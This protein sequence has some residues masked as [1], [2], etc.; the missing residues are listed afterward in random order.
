M[1][2]NPIIN[3]DTLN[4]ELKSLPNRLDFGTIT[5]LASQVTSQFQAVKQSTLSTDVN[6]VVNGFQ[7]LTQEVDDGFSTTSEKG[8]AVLTENPPGLNIKKPT[9]GANADL[10]AMTGDTVD[11]G[12]LDFVVTAPTPEATSKALSQVTGQPIDKIS[13][14]VGGL[15]PQPG[16]L[17]S[18]LG[19]ITKNIPIGN[20]LLSQVSQFTSGLQRQL[21][22]ALSGNVKNVAESLNSG[23]NPV[24]NKIVNQPLP[25]NIRDQVTRLVEQG[26][27]SQAA[28]ILTQYSALSVTEIEQLL[29]TVPTTVSEQVTDPRSTARTT[30]PTKN[31]QYSETA[32]FDNISSK[33]E[34]D[35]I[36]LGAERDITEVV[37]H[38]TATYLDQFLDANDID[39]AHKDRG[40]GRIGYHFLILR[41]GTLQRGRPINEV[42]AHA[43][44]HNSFSIGVAFVGGI[45]LTAAQGAAYGGYQKVANDSRFASAN[46]LTSTQMQTFDWFMESFFTAYPFGQALGHND[47]DRNNKLD[48][49]FDVVQYVKSRFNKNVI[50]DPSGSSLSKVALLNLART[51][52]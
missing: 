11:G 50:V 49:G 51:V 15:S 36:L 9:S 52:G 46:S 10:Q 22:S 43:L 20:S 39:R 32:D 12:F 21:G 37:V 26:N 1:S 42:G 38:W 8:V 47:I 24:L 28:N 3:F 4:T 29:Q 31:I 6:K 40:F 13:S 25:P 16:Q 5:N 18:A 19:D 23:F 2:K 48:P 35:G 33:E 27:T 34:L 44:R 7:S 41:D 17:P 30:T 14:A 45:N